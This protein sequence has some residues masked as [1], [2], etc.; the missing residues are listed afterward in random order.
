MAFVTREK[1]RLYWRADGDE[2][3]PPLLLLN[4]L[5]TDHAMWNAVM[6]LLTRDFR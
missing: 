2:A 4:S 5:G 1:A 6:P 3:K